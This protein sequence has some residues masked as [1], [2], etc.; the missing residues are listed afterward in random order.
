MAS[1]DFSMAVTVSPSSLSTAQ[2]EAGIISKELIH[3]YGYTQVWKA[4]LSRD[5][6]RFIT[7]GEII[8]EEQKE[9]GRE[10]RGPAVTTTGYQPV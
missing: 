4:E 5:M 1:V 9:D 8:D 3:E 10:L 7:E 6:F 2:S